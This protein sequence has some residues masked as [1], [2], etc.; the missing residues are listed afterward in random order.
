MIENIQWDLNGLSAWD[1]DLMNQ[2]KFSEKANRETF[3]SQKKN[4]F[5]FWWLTEGRQ[6]GESWVGS[7]R[8]RSQWNG[9]NWIMDYAI[10]TGGTMV[11]N[12]PANEGDT[13]DMGS[14]P[15]SGRSHG[16]GN[17]LQYSCLKNPMDRGAWRATVHGVAKSWTW[18]GDSTTETARE[19]T[20]Q[21]WEELWRK[22]AWDSLTNWRPEHLNTEIPPTGRSSR[23]LSGVCIFGLEQAPPAAH[24][25]LPH[26]CKCQ[27]K[28]H[29]VKEA[30]PAC[31]V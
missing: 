26:L 9:L 11:K 13:G 25:T 14:I 8:K 15:G 2:P 21:S 22:K 24:D 7:Q 23:V 5:P 10:R 12:M 1:D 18:L 27:L 3:R 6:R 17:P 31:S 16:G 4:L 20:G 30:C 19:K 29:C 28:G